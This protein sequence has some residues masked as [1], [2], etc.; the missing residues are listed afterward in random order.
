MN[1]FN[2]PSITIIGEIGE[3]SLRDLCYQMS[4]LER[5]RV[6]V[7]HIRIDICSKGGCTESG[8]AMANRIKNS[9]LTSHIYGMSEVASSALLIFLSGH[10]R[11]SSPEC[12]YLYHEPSAGVEDGRISQ[13]K[14]NI[15]EL[16]HDVSRFEMAM[17]RF[18]GLSSTYWNSLSQKKHDTIFSPDEMLE[19]GLIQK[20]IK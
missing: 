15:S 5:T 4:E 16:E 18:S 10:N 6:G 7:K 14:H 17:E 19:L 12:Y 2:L 8:M 9:K 1:I 20:I 11:Y 13:L 3:N